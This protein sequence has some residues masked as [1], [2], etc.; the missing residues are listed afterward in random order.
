[1]VLHSLRRRTGF[2]LPAGHATTARRA[3]TF[4]WLG[5][6]SFL[7]DKSSF[8]PLD[9]GV[10][11]HYLTLSCKK[12]FRKNESVSKKICRFLQ[13]VAEGCGKS[14]GQSH[15]VSILVSCFQHKSGNCLSTHPAK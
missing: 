14:H 7:R 1:M 10:V 5:I 13:K 15:F 11:G 3:A 6:F 4:L 8:K 9:A 2:S 12:D